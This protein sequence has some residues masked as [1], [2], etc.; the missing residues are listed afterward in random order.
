MRSKMSAAQ[1]TNLMESAYLE[2]FVSKERVPWSRRIAIM[3]RIKIAI[4]ITIE[5]GFH[6]LIYGLILIMFL[7]VILIV[8]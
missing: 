8:P 7:I 6:G 5:R 3:I 4:R 2:L 1:P